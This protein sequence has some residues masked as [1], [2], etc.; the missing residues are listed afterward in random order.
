MTANKKSMNAAI[1]VAGV[2][3]VALA[4]GWMLKSSFISAVRQVSVDGITAELPA[5]WLIDQRDSQQ[6]S[7]GNIDVTGSSSQA[8]IANDPEASPNRVFSSWDPLAPQLR[9]TISRVPFDAAGR[10]ADAAAVR[11]LLRAQVLSSYRV[12]DQTPVTLKGR[13]GYRVSFAFVDASVPNQVPVV[14]RGADYF[15]QEGESVLIVTLETSGNYGDA[16]P[17]FQEFAYTVRQGE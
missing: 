8:Q 7:L 6:L 11:N 5:N 12:L 2:T 4:L 1:L 16:L 17:A 3:L 9:Y 10:L 15:F 13:D 14:L